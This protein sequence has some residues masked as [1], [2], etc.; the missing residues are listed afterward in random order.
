MK[1]PAMTASHPAHPLIP[2]DRVNGTDVVNRAGTKLGKIEDVAIDKVSGEVAYA[3]LS[4]GG[5]LG[6]GAKYHPV[7]WRLLTYD[8]DKRAYVI[9]LDK[10]ALETAPMIDETELS[11]W[12]DSLSRDAIYGYYSTYGVGPYWG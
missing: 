8:A 1:E 6:I 12:N 11:G 10:D 2:A 3:I 7:P 5:V 9:P 4:F